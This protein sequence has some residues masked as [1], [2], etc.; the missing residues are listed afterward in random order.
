MGRNRYW[1]YPWRK[2]KI[3]TSPRA[4][5]RP[6]RSTPSIHMK[7]VTLSLV[8][9]VAVAMLLLSGQNSRG[10]AAEPAT[11][12]DKIEFNRDIRPI[13]SD[14]CYACH[15]PDGRKREAA[16]RLDQEKPAKHELE[17]GATAI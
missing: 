3:E 1:T 14:N 8:V 6:H 15:G 5:S 16:L 17:S 4:T 7:R 11:L 2:F 12:P 10:L 9:P 13:L